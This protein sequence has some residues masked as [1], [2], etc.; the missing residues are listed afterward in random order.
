[1]DNLLK[2]TEDNY[3]NLYPLKIKLI[4]TLT[5]AVACDIP[6]RTDTIR[7]VL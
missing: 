3:G 4:L 1:M 7:F 6:E 2:I 5:L